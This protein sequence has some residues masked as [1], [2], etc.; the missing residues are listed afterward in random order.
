MDTV[1][2]VEGDTIEII[3]FNHYG[4]QT[5]DLLDEVFFADGNE[6]LPRSGVFLE[7]GTIVHLPTIVEPEGTKE[8]KRLQNLWD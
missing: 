8:L 6:T 7:P 1:R 5:P 4:R 2:S 3:V